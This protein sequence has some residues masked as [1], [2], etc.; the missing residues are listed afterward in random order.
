M[1]VTHLLFPFLIE[2]SKLQ[3]G[4]GTY[5]IDLMVYYI[6]DGEILW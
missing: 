1:S 4:L 2:V 3:L 6:V 5:L